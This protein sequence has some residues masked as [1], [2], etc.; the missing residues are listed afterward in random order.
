[1]SRCVILSAVPVGLWAKALLKKDDQIIA[2]DAGYKNA[3][4]LGIVPNQ[5][6][7][8]FDS[9]PQPNV[10]N[11]IVLP[12]E[13]DDTDT[14]YAARIA[15]EKGFQQVLML[16]AL[17]GARLEHT[18]ANLAT[19]L[20]LA[21]QGI[22]VEL[23]NEKSRITYVL[24]DRAA[25]LEH[26]ADEYFSLFPMEGKAEGVS[27]SGAKYSADGMTLCMD[28]PIGVSNETQPGTTRITVE[29]GVLILICTK[30]GNS[31]AHK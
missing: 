12:A 17:G 18:L 9:A 27:I 4:Y 1:M 30:K 8:D 15:A 29:K 6:L 23:A 19:G 7:G 24:P 22:S 3:E 31:D 14:H 2:C 25:E 13:K 11:A 10:S 16:G 26:H 5:V 20:W 21:K 28:Y